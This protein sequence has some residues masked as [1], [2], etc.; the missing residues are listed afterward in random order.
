MQP[1]PAAAARPPAPKPKRLRWT[2]LEWFLVAQSFIPALLFVPGVS[3]ARVVIRMAIFLAPLATWFAIVQ[4]GRSKAGSDTYSPALWLKLIIGWLA[5]SLFHWQTPSIIGG[6]AQATFYIAVFSPGF[7]VPK[8]LG[9]P[10][11][12]NRLMA[13]LLI[14]NGI[15]T[16]VALGQVFRPETFNPPVIPGITGMPEDS[17]SVLALTYTDQYG[18]KILRPCGLGDTPGGGAM[19]GAVAALVGLATALRPIGKLRRLACLAMAFGGMAV[20]YYSQVRMIFVMT[21]IC[22]AVLAAV[23]VLQKNFG[24]ATL[25][26]G[27][28]AAMVVGALSWV[29]ATSGRVVVERF[30]GLTERSFSESYYGS[31]RGGL[32]QFALTHQMWEAP[33]GMGLGGWGV[34]P[35]LVGAA[36]NGVWVELMITGWVA[37]GGIPLLTLNFIALIAAMINTL[38]IALRS[39][40]RDIRFWAAVVFASNLSAIATCF[41]WVTFITVIGMQFWFQAALVHAADY[42]SRREAALAR[43]RRSAPRPPGPPPFPSPS[44]AAPA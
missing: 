29:M 40:D 6:A 27:L 13:I 3:A 42:Q 5:L 1:R 25:L 21:I 36:P 37:D 30:L 14:C 33:L 32:V 34:A 35:G 22:L 43:A 31:A 20:I 12:L 26:G 23:F 19:A 16:A 18:R 9:S 24:Y 44:P 38:R 39:R 8:G 41:S 11:Q 7:W 15:S 28:G 17:L 10:R 2:P 4:S